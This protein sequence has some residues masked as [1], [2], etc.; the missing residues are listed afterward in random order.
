MAGGQWAGR[1]NGSG[2]VIG[3]RSSETAGGWGASY[4]TGDIFFRKSVNQIT[5]RITEVTGGLR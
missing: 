3:G 5:G 4:F 1:I 2:A